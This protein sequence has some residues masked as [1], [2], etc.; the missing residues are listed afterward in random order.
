MDTINSSNYNFLYDYEFDRQKKF[1]ALVIF[2]SSS[3]VFVFSAVGLTDFISNQT[4]EFLKIHLGLTNKWSTTFGPEWFVSLNKDVSAL[5]GFLLISIFF[6]IT[7]IYYRLRKESRRL[8]RFAF[9]VLMGAIMML[10]VKMIVSNELIDDHSEII[11]GTVSSF[12]SGHAMMGTIFYGTLA[13]TI[14][15]R[16]H[17]KRTKR[18]TLFSGI[19]IIILIGISRVLPGIHT[20]NEVIAGWSLGLTWL[21]LCWFLERY[22]KNARALQKNSNH[23]PNTKK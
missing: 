18:L 9:I 16:Q 6:T 14:S 23:S 22:I 12:P 3:L 19:V 11:I 4:S 2:I 5:G 20:L 21:C 1:I 17:S 8:W 10:I 7:I 13:V 15:R